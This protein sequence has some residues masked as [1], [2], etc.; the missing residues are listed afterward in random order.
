MSE[1]DLEVDR[2]RRAFASLEGR[3]PGAGCPEPERLWS[4]AR[5]ELPADVVRPL[6]LH[7]VEC[8]AC[9]E[10]WRLARE[11]EPR[12]AQRPVVVARPAPAR[13]SWTFWGTLA[14]GITVALAASVVLNRQP[15]RTSGFREGTRSDIRSLVP[16]SVALARDRCVLRW[17]PGPEG[18][19][20]NV[21]VATERLEKISEARGSKSA[22]YQVPAQALGSLPSGAKLLWRVE[23]VAP[24]G[25]RATS[26][27]FVS[28]LE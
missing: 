3:A 2:L 4:A 12:P 27:T 23:A 19:T 10:A 22:T 17:S 5:G 26:A 7:L 16:E 1:I 6:V 18:T 14:A 28:R 25:T 11:V 20:Y 15:E 21:Q 24:D 13:P 8:S 9:A